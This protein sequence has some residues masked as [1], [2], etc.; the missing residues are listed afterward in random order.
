MVA[1]KL[2]RDEIKNL[3]NKASGLESLAN[4]LDKIKDGELILVQ[5]EGS[6]KC[7]LGNC[8]GIINSEC[9]L[10]I[11]LANLALVVRLDGRYYLRNGEEARKNMQEKWGD[12]SVWIAEGRNATPQEIEEAGNHFYP[13][14]RINR[15]I[16]RGEKRIVKVLENYGIS[17]QEYKNMFGNF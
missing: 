14:I 15:R 11:K 4:K 17:M 9:S 1:T 13:T 10:K 12:F 7:F 2:L 6:Y 5:T 8:N 3:R 16:V